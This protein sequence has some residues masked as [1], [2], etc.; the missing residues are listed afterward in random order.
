MT[1][2]IVGLVI[3]LNIYVTVQT[4][5]RKQ[6]VS[7]MISVTFVGVLSLV[8]AFLSISS[9]FLGYQVAVS[10]RGNAVLLFQFGI[11]LIFCQIYPNVSETQDV[12]ETGQYT[13]IYIM[14]D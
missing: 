10:E 12:N 6:R 5:L 8:A 13:K 1:V 7:N 11:L 2:A 9:V 3:V 14:L 4:L